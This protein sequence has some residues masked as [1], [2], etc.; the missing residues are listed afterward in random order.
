MNRKFALIMV[1]AAGSLAGVAAAQSVPVTDRGDRIQQRLDNRGD[2]IENRFDAR[3]AHQE[4]LGH[5]RRA[6]WLDNRGE[7]INNHL[8]HR[9]DR[10]DRRFDRRGR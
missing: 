2:R 7:R 4:T 6:Q 10:I 3:S 1:I 5:T 9:G 8:E